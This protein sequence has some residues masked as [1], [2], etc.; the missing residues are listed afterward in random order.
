MR[1]KW[2]EKEW[3]LNFIAVKINNKDTWQ[4]IYYVYVQDEERIT[5]L[6]GK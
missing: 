3:K 6:E 5:N 4:L 1:P 2:K